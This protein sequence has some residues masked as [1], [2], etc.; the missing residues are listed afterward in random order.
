MGW[1]WL[2]PR[3]DSLSNQVQPRILGN[4]WVYFDWKF[5][6]WYVLMG[7]GSPHKKKM[8]KEQSN[9]YYIYNDFEITFSSTNE[10]YDMFKHKDANAS[11]PNNVLICNFFTLFAVARKRDDCWENNAFVAGSCVK[12]YIKYS[13]ILLTRISE[14]PSRHFVNIISRNLHIQWHIVTDNELAWLALDNDW[15]N[16]RKIVERSNLVQK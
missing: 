6:I 10:L 8:S 15:Q 3:R 1:Q 2:F 4:N 12:F 7:M 16:L 5:G 13:S 11:G 14:V 9:R